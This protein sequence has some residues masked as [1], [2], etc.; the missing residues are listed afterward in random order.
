MWALIKKE[1]RKKLASN[2]LQHQTEEEFEQ[3]V[4]DVADA[5]AQKHHRGL[6]RSNIRYLERYLKKA[7][8]FGIDT[9]GLI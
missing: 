5:V 6:C 9:T 7:E 2:P 8:E 3:A 4:K 1:F